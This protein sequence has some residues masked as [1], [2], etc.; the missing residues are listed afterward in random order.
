[1]TK[2]A[3][4]SRQP[5]ADGY[6]VMDE[7]LTVV[8]GREGAPPRTQDAR[9]V[10]SMRQIAAARLRSCGLE[11]MTA[12]VLL[13]VSELLTNALLHS[14]TTE[15]SLKLTAQGGFLHISVRDGV[16]SVIA[17]VPASRQ[18]ESGRGLTLVAA[19][20]REDGGTCGTSNDGAVA[21]CTLA[22]AS[23]AT[24]KGKFNTATPPNPPAERR[25]R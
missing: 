9:Q 2:A 18:A 24:A 12:D 10:G 3:V 1:M 21:W 7:R 16:P 6:H 19:L 17:P 23:P 14:G 4:G 25:M 5:P 20:A 11:A 22:I 15:I 13:V 8:P